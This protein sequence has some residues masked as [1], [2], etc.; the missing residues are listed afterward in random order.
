MIRL[1]WKSKRTLNRILFSNFSSARLFAAS[2]NQVNLQVK[3]KSTWLRLRGLVKGGKPV[4]AL[5]IRYSNAPTL[6]RGNTQA[7]ADLGVEQT[8]V[9]TPEADG[10]WLRKDVRVCSIQ[11]VWN[12]LQPMGVLV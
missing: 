10:Y 8:L 1:Y 5:E 7:I 9:V 11:G 6:T 3:Y 2:V 4:V 12:I